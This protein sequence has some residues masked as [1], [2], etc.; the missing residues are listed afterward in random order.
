MKKFLLI[1]I[2]ILCCFAAIGQSKK[3]SNFLAHFKTV[4]SGKWLLVT[5]L[6]TLKKTSSPLKAQTKGF[7][8]TQLFVNIDDANNKSINADGWSLHEG[9]LGITIY[10]TP[11]VTRNSFKTDF[12]NPQKS[13]IAFTDIGYTIKGKDSFLVLYHFNEAKKLL[14]ITKFKKSSTPS[15]ISSD[16]FLDY[17]VNKTLFTGNYS[18]KD[19]EGNNV[20]ISFT[21]EGGIYGLQ[22]FT[23]YKVSTF[24]L[25][26]SKGNYY[27][28][29]YFLD[30]DN[31]PVLYA[32]TF[33]GKKLFLYELT[34]NKNEQMVLGSLKYNLIKK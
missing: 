24:I 15:I 23:K 26:R 34:E 9:G 33:V 17:V 31:A 19:N 2:T 1:F 27:N 13:N 10:F 5:Y 3:S 6:E 4:V 11:G 12:H 8:L 28:K 16:K 21:N 30:N 32:F 29:I 22:E 14:Q 20:N 7:D 18:G 25:Q